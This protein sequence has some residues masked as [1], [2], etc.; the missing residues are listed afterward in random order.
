MTPEMEARADAARK[1][2]EELRSLHF[3]VGTFVKQAGRRGKVL[4]EQ[5]CG[6]KLGHRSLTIKWDDGEITTITPIA[7]NRDGTQHDLDWK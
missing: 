2:F 1:A 4:T 6:C 3:A 5:P 7:L